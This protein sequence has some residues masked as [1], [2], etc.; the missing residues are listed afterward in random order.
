M[1][2]YKNIFREDGIVTWENY[3]GKVTNLIWNDNETGIT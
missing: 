1:S 2:A 3:A